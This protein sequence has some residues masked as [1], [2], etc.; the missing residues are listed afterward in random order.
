ME[1]DSS[2]SGREGRSTPGGFEAKAIPCLSPAVGR[3]ASLGASGLVDPSPLS[4]YSGLPS[5]SLWSLNSMRT[6]GTG[7][8]GHPQSR[9]I[10]CPLRTSRRP[11]GKATLTGCGSGLGDISGGHSSTTERAQGCA[12]LPAWSRKTLVL[13]RSMEWTW[14]LHRSSCEPFCPRAP[15]LPAGP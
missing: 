4:I 3:P 7:L 2:S 8:R 9:M 12:E 14:V 13:S 11:R 15:Q 5:V 1:I 10:S 6:P